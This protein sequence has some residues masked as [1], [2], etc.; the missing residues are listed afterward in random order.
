MTPPRISPTWPGSCFG[1]SPDN[2]HGLHLR[3]TPTDE[4]CI[5][6]STIPSALC[7]FDGLVHGGIIATLLDE[8]AGW[9]IFL[10]LGKLGVTRE[11]TT[12]YLK[13]VPIGQEVVVEGRIVS[14]D[15]RNA[16]VRSTVSATD[17]T[18]LAEGE[19]SW[20]FPRLSRMAAL[21]GVPE[22]TLQQF[23]DSCCGNRQTGP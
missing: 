3:F 9:T 11:M 23:L 6:R 7:G 19:S 21:A 10:R 1:C 2:P 16:L 4:G 15:E 22:E 5:T 14:C 12:R 18:V 20:A 13:P 17:G 8:A